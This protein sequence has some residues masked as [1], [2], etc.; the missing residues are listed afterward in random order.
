VRIGGIAFAPLFAVRESF[1]RWIGAAGVALVVCPRVAWAHAGRAPEPHD[2]WSSWTLAPVVI[3]GLALGCWWY[4]RGVR[5]L[6]RSAGQG[7]GIPRWR[8]A[9]FGGGVLATALALLSP[10]DAVAAALFAAHMTQ[11]MLLVVVAAPL[12]VLGDVATASLWALRVDARRALGGWW[13]ARRALSALWEVLR[14]PIVAFTLHVGALWLWHLPTLYDAALRHEGVH[15]AEHASFFV[16]ALLFWYPIADPHRRARFGV[17]VATLYLFAAGLQC[18]LLGALI[19]FARH[20]WYA[21]HYG[22]TAAWGLTPLEDQQLAGL[23]MWIPAGLVYLVALIPTVLPVL[24]GAG[25]WAARPAA[26][27]VSAR[28]TP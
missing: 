28:G 7:R 3:V 9:C 10:I 12:L 1:G 11:H 8:V 21:G 27:G 24:R 6:W 18:T 16:T 5:A 25:Q 23:I 17:G 15:V 22:T 26:A 19:T 2:L 13:R 14:R 4:A 20:P